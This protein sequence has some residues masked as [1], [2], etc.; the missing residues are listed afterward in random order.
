LHCSKHGIYVECFISEICQKS[1]LHTQFIG[2]II[3]VK[4]DEPVLNADGPSDIEKGDPI[5]YAPSC[6]TYHDIGNKLEDVFSMGKN[7]K[8]RK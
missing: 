2:E 5:V 8:A 3:D 7:I 4:T 1:G 6:S